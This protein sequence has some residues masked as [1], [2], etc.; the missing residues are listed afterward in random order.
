MKPWAM[1]QELKFYGGVLFIYGTL[2]VEYW[3]AFLMSPRKKLV[4][5]Y[6]FMKPT[7]GHVVWDNEFCIL[8]I[9]GLL[10]SER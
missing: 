1:Q 5:S 3:N 6:L 9:A 4:I 2:C 8:K 7:I 10:I